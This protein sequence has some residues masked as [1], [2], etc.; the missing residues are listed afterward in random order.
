MQKQLKLQINPKKALE[1]PEF[2]Y[3]AKKKMK[4]FSKYAEKIQKLSY[5]ECKDNLIDYLNKNSVYRKTIKERT[6]DP[7]ELRQ[8]NKK[9]QKKMKL[10]KRPSIKKKPPQ[11][12]AKTGEIRL[13]D[14]SPT[15]IANKRLLM[16]EYGK[17]FNQPGEFNEALYQSSKTKYIL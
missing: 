13:R 6:L 2:A 1:N 17:W 11:L 5:I 8:F 3:F 7:Y 15:K 9:R 12:Y 16:E 10:L 4:D 14:V